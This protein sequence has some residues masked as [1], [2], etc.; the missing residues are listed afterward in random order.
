MSVVE[1]LEKVKLFIEKLQEHI[2]ELKNGVTEDNRCYYVYAVYVLDICTFREY[3]MI[4]V[5]NQTDIAE[6]LAHQ[7]RYEEILNLKNFVHT[8]KKMTE[9]YNYILE[10]APNITKENFE[11]DPIVKEHILNMNNA[12]KCQKYSPVKYNAVK[13][14]ANQ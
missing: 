3:K 12:L 13:P 2:N 10:N 1:K 4:P 5:T 6:L 7:M 8:H 14:P 9:S 11:N